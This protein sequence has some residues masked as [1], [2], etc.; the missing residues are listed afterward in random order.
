MAAILILFFMVR[1]KQRVSG[2]FFKILC[3]FLAIGTIQVILA[4]FFSDRQALAFREFLLGFL[5]PCIILLFLSTRKHLQSYFF[6]SFFL[7]YTIFLIIVLALLFY[8][9][10]ETLF[11]VFKQKNGLTG[12]IFLRYCYDMYFLRFFGNVNSSTNYLTLAL[13]IA[14]II[15]T[16]G[17]RYKKLLLMLFFVASIVVIVLVYTRAAWL[18]LPFIV[19]IHF[20]LWWKA[21][22][23]VSLSLLTVTIAFEREKTIPELNVI[24][25]YLV[26]AKIKTTPSP[27][28][29]GTM[30]KRFSQ[31][32]ELPEIIAQNNLPVYRIV[33]HGIGFDQY[34]LLKKYKNRDSKTHNLFIDHFL[35]NG[36][37]VLF[38]ILWLLYKGLRISYEQ[39]QW[40]CF[41]GFIIFFLL[42]FHDYDFCRLSSINVGSYLFLFLF[43]PLFH[44]P[45]ISEQKALKET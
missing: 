13:L 21:L 10:R 44:G 16:G 23:F 26:H 28:F 29:L 35:A 36:I 5:S 22:L 43:W 12:L 45:G 1:D 24:Y 32:R 14:P 18:L 40:V 8:K 17:K 31:W 3:A 2:Q 27:G 4:L 38:I 41:I 33:L 34:S 39:K 6:Y 19:I 7:S 30:N 42:C 20:K 9:D 11:N 37:F 15:L 25:Q